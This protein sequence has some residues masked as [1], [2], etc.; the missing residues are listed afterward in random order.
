MDASLFFTLEIQYLIHTICFWALHFQDIEK[1]K[2]GSPK[3]FN[4]LNKS[5][6]YDLV[7]VSD[8]HEYLA[9]RRAMDIV[10][11]STQEQVAQTVSI[12]TLL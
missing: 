11:I 6:C 10:G 5:N 9:T 12:C 4:Y 1:Y 7:G 3:T 8:A 2:L